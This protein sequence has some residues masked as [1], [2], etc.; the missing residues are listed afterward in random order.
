MLREE[1]AECASDEEPVAG[2]LSGELPTVLVCVRPF[3]QAMHDQ[4][5]RA[6]GAAL[7]ADEL[8]R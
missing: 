3:D 5:T 1:R 7:A 2:A 4:L 8:G 6:D